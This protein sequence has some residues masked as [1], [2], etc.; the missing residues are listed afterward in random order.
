MR[1]P[2]LLLGIGITLGTIGTVHTLSSTAAFAGD[3]FGAI[4]TTEDSR[5]GGAY[6][7]PSRAQA[8]AA[9]LQECGASDCV[10]RVWFKNACGAVAENSSLIGVGW[11]E[12]RAE[13][14]AQAISTVGTGDAKILSWGCTDR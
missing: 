1:I 12:T 5:W 6:N 7:Y 9:A 11:G 13:A 8:E 3:M 2:K 14:E 4:A 10:V